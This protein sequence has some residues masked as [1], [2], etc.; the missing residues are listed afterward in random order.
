[1]SVIYRQY[2]SRWG[3]LSYHKGDTMAS[4]GCGATSCA[5]VIANTSN[6]SVTPKTTRAFMLKHN[7]AVKNAGTAW[8]GI[9]ACLKNW[10]Y[11]VKS[12]DTM[13]SVKQVISKE[14]FF[15]EVALKVA[16]HGLQVVIL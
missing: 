8:S 10:G 6:R 12:C 15:L 9:P 14:L 1:M 5:N 16:L 11:I 7:Y 3:N 2:D 4:S 13:E